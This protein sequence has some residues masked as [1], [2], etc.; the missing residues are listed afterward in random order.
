M[1]MALLHSLD[2][3]THYSSSTTT[4]S[5]SMDRKRTLELEEKDFFH[6]NSTNSN[7][8]RLQSNKTVADINVINSTDHIHNMF[9]HDHYR[10]PS[11]RV[12][13]GLNL[14]T[15][16]HRSDQSQIEEEL[17]QTQLNMRVE[18]E[19]MTE[20]NRKLRSM[21]DQLT[22]NYTIL[23]TQLLAINQ[24]K[25]FNPGL[26]IV[27]NQN[28]DTDE[29][30]SNHMSS[31]TL[32]AHQF[33]EPGPSGMSGDHRHPRESVALDSP[34]SSHNINIDQQA[35]ASTSKEHYAAADIIKR[36]PAFTLE[37][38]GTTDDIQTTSSQLQSCG[39]NDKKPASKLEKPARSSGEQVPADHDVPNC[40][41][42]RVSVRARS[43]APMMS[44]GCQWRK[45]GQKMAKG[46]PCP[47]AYYRCTMAVACP[48][49]KKVQRCAEDSSILITTYEGNHNHPLPPTATAMA[50]AT[51][52]A[53]S[54]LLSGST[55]SKDALANC[56]FFP[57]LSMATILASA[58]FPTIT[59]DLTNT[60]TTNTP[61]LMHYFQR[62][63]YDQYRSTPFAIPLQGCPQFFGYPS[64]AAA[65]PTPHNI[66]L[67]MSGSPSAMQ[68]IR[69]TAGQSRELCSLNLMETMSGAT[70]T[71]P[72]FTAALAAAISS[73]IGVACRTT[74]NDHIGNGN[75]SC[76]VGGNN[77]NASTSTVPTSSLQMPPVQPGSP[78]LP[79][80]C[81]TLPTN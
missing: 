49:R 37:D 40:R 9:D 36:P 62:P 25:R 7:R 33:M 18:V 48:V 42:A 39:D 10:R 43:D 69:A 32:S 14:L 54:M 51:S 50:N 55:T 13:T 17:K 57:H 68:V 35:A 19:R 1:E 60:T 23:H 45:Y 29:N 72:N 8:R 46:N 28:K 71:D 4:S 41:K 53:A 59:L 75:G 52:A 58:P 61:N 26:N 74:D 2:H 76:D 47:R 24:Q 67:M 66:K 21:L 70:A 73:I 80:S 38:D 6:M 22:R 15:I 30:E 34:N 44:D 56:A 20:E 81:T 77:S 79:Q 27:D 63:S 11:C 3:V 31:P 16:N 78:Q 5:T 64:P 65:S 12:N